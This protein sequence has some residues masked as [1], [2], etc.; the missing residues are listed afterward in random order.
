MKNKYWVLNGKYYDL[1]Q[2][3]ACSMPTGIIFRCMGLK[4]FRNF[5]ADA[6]CV[7]DDKWVF[8]TIRK[9]RHECRTQWQNENKNALGDPKTR[10]YV[11]TNQIRQDIIHWAKK[12]NKTDLLYAERGENKNGKL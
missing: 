10:E 7:I 12:Q 8:D 3:N 4:R 5:A 2:F 11:R 9:V 1:S 6:N